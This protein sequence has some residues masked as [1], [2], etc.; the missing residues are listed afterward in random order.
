MWSQ[1]SLPAAGLAC[2]GVEVGDAL[3]IR[4]NRRRTRVRIRGLSGLAH[5]SLDFERELLI[6]GGPDRETHDGEADQYLEE[7]F[8]CIREAYE[9]Q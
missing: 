8:P 3:G 7:G 2:L 9:R 5:L 4:H 1:I 6:D